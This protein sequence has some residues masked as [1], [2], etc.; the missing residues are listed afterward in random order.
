MDVLSSAS[1]PFCEGVADP[2]VAAEDGHLHAELARLSGDDRGL[3]V[4]AGGKQDI[5]LFAADACERRLEIGVAARVADRRHDPAAKSG[6][7]LGDR[8]SEADGEVL[9]LVAED[10]DL[11]RL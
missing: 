11:A 10:G 2:A 4:V 8:I 9:R 3:G 1:R 6:E 7:V 5:R